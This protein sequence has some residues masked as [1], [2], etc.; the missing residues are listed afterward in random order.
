MGKA[1]LRPFHFSGGE[2]LRRM[3]AKESQT[4]KPSGAEDGASCAFA[5]L[6]AGVVLTAAAAGMALTTSIT[7]AR[8]T[9]S[10]GRCMAS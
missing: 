3:P 4:P 1:A 2:R 8:R 9:R 5:G 6:I 7:H 10:L